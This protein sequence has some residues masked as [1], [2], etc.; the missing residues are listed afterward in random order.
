MGDPGRV[1]R[2][3]D[4]TPSSPLVELDDPRLARAGVRVI[5]KR[6][7][8]IH[9]LLPGNKW[10]KLKYNLARAAELGHETLLTFGGAY[11]NH[12]RAV[13]AA[14]AR[15]GFRTVGVIRGEEHL[16]LNEVLAFAAG[17]GM[18]LVYLDRATYRVKDTAPVVEELRREFGRFY[19]LPEGGS[20]EQAV[21]GCAELPGEIGVPF[22]V[23]CCP[24]GTGG[25]LAG[26]AAGLATGQRAL[27]FSVLRGGR[28]LADVVAGLQVATY[29][30]VSANWTVECDFHAGGYA[31]RGP[32]L[33]AFADD[34]A[35]RHGMSL[36]RVYVAKMMW[37]VFTL[38]ERGV[39]PGDTTVV[40]VV[41]GPMKV[42]LS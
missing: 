37:G 10:R 23:V 33:D 11:S 12:V 17:A 38:V 3:F 32:E 25:T 2:E 22:D 7:D 24:V 9:P 5:L 41:T 42:A 27:G 19:L 8:L 40:A 20:N 28:F 34:F 39:F 4:R 35:H 36:D 16:P 6:D 30:E 26:I 15:F 29:G 31:R 1:R 14:G 13:A 18:R 21:R